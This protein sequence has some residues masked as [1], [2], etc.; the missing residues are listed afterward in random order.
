MNRQHRSIL[1]ELREDIVRDIDVNDG[2]LDELKEKLKLTDKHVAKIMSG[3]TVQN[4]VEIMLDI[5]P[6]YEPNAFQIFQNAI[7]DNWCWIYEKME[8]LNTE[9]KKSIC[10]PPISP[11]TVPREEKLKM[12]LTKLEPGGYVVL[13]GM[14]GFGK[15]SLTA[16]TLKNESLVADL[17]D[18][19]VYW[20]K[21]AYA[22][23]DKLIDTEILSQ[24]NSLYHRVNNASML[25]LGP[26]SKLSKDSLIQQLKYHFSN[27]KNA[28]VVLNDVWNPNIIDSFDFGCKTLV[29]TTNVDLLGTNRIHEVVKMMDGFTEDESLKL[30]AD[31][32]GIES[33]EQLPEEARSIHY[34]CNGMP[35]LIAMFAAQFQQYK[36]DMKVNNERWKYY[37]DALRQKDKSNKVISKFLDK[38]NAIFDM[39]IDQLTEPTKKM[40][41]QLAIFSEDVNITS[42]TL[43]ILWDEDKIWAVDDHMNEIC[44]KSLAEKQFNTE[45]NGY[46]YGVH[47]LL[48]C[49]LQNAMSPD[50]LINNHKLFVEKYRKNCRNDFSKLPNDNYGYSY[51]GYHLEQAEMYDEFENLYLDLNFIQSKINYCG[52]NDLLIDI[53]RYKNYIIAGK[54]DNE[55]KI[56]EWE[57]F[58]RSH[59]RII[60]EHSRRNCLDLVQIGINDLSQGYIYNISR[61]I[62]QKRSTYLYLTH[63]P[64]E[65]PQSYVSYV[66][67]TDLCTINFTD[68][69]TQ[70]LIGNKDGEIISWNTETHKRTTYNSH[71]KSKLKKVILSKRDIFFL[72]L[73]DKGYIE[74]FNYEID[75]ANEINN[76]DRHC[77]QSPREK[78]SFWSGIHRNPKP[79]NVKTYMIQDNKY[80]HII[81]D[82]ALS[83]DDTTISAC[84]LKG[85]VRVWNINGDIIFT[86]D[87]KERCYN[88]IAFLRR[89]E[90]LSMVDS[91][92]GV[93][94]VYHKKLTSDGYIY[95]TL[96]RPKHTV[97]HEND[98]PKT[99]GIDNKKIIYFN[100]IPNNDEPYKINLIM[101]TNLEAITI[102]FYEFMS[103]PGELVNPQTRFIADIDNKTNPTMRYITG[104]LTHDGNYFIIGDSEGFVKVWQVYGIDKPYITFTG[105]INVLDTYC[106]DES[107]HLIIGASNRVIH[108][109]LFLT[110]KEIAPKSPRKPLF[111]AIMKPYGESDIVAQ[112]SDKKISIHIGQQIKQTEPIAGEIISLSLSHDGNEILYIVKIIVGKNTIYKIYIYDGNKSYEI[113]TLTQYISFAK[114]LRIHDMNIAVWEQGNDLGIK[115]LEMEVEAKNIGHIIALHTIS[116]NNVKYVIT[117]AS[118]KKIIIWKVSDA[119]NPFWTN[120]YSTQ[121]TIDETVTSSEIHQ[122]NYLAVLN[123]NG[124]LEIYSIVKQE[125]DLELQLYITRN[126]IIKLTCCAFSFDSK[127]LAIGMDNGEIIIFDMTSYIIYKDL[128]LH[129]NAIRQ[130]FWAPLSVDQPILLSLTCDEMAWWNIS[131]MKDIKQTNRRSRHGPLSRSVTTPTMGMSPRSSMRL[132]KSQTTDLSKLTLQLEKLENNN[133]HNNDD[134]DDNNNNKNNTDN[135]NNNNKMD[136]FDN[137]SEFWKSKQ[138]RD[139][140]RSLL[141]LTQLPQ[142]SLAKVC[143]SNDFK[144]F[145][146]VDAYGSINTFGLFI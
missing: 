80:I 125:N 130:L 95:K 3:E 69:P 9:P 56:E 128:P 90:F 68:E 35:I 39:C 99:V 74:K 144:K 133:H 122:N 96:Y 42:Q 143:V 110:D 65:E 30:F 67:P 16:S 33:I 77:L 27:N 129:C 84:T 6:E 94:Y 124:I 19:Q 92:A 11:L 57:I 26:E 103:N 132:P 12:A 29:I 115:S 61:K 45:L 52:L 98:N 21:F 17:F 113:K 86:D 62:A 72:A 7:K 5:I 134:D 13:H 131:Y 79:S 120:I 91:R 75:Q 76:D 138:P 135:N 41:K 38:Q 31:S 46:V 43:T 137:S 50:E 97:Y 142:S 25:S 100:E 63:K 81:E 2:V 32:L 34:E 47:D 107:Y 119:I 10:I 48:L 4:K 18:N 121:S 60:A 112:V 53:N 14:K 78:Q 106:I 126:F 24:L 37:S 55:K 20:I 54:L 117:V 87:C 59:S 23:S 1:I 127:Y 73:N 109:W 146:L 44:K 102:N 82:F 104:T 145:L 64:V 40:Y 140:K 89:D 139:S 88:C 116:V 85:I 136:L 8:K 101:I 123:S 141:G 28:L 36:D 83:S 15:H 105:R 58:L 118:N 71:Q 66:S 114:F 51:I 111:D 93:I 108:K 49:H 70:I 22:S